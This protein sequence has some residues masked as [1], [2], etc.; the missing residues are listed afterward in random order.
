MSADLVP[1]PVPGSDRQVMATVVD[2]KPVVSLRHA[3][4]GIGIAFDAQRVKL[5]SKSWAVVT[6][7]VSTGSDGKSYE[8]TM[9]D[10]RTFT[11]WLATIDTKRVSKEARP[12]LE[13]FQAEA[14]DALDA[15]FNEGAAINPR[16]AVDPLPGEDQLDA[17][18]ERARAQAGVLQSLKGLIDPKHLEAKGRVLLARA[19]GEAPEIADQDVPL[20]VWDYLRSKGLPNRLI[21]AKARGF[22]TK[23]KA[24]YIAKHDREPERHQRKLS[25]GSVRLFNAYTEADRPLFD[26]VW[27]RHYAMKVAESALFPTDGGVS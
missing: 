3:C 13:A 10:R 20:Y 5:N 16:A 6:I 19:L 7:I 12:I 2:G 11:M 23:L 17:V 21:E 9:I 27:A 22:G 15:Y 18:I 14:A 26:S 1:I 25:D 24:L 4:D 8:M